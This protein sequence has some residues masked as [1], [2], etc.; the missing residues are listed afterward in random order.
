MIYI[1]FLHVLNSIS[2]PR[3]SPA[4]DWVIE[5]NTRKKTT[6]IYVCA[7]MYFLLT[8]NEN[9]LITKLL[10]FSRNFPPLSLDFRR[11][12]DG[13]TNLWRLAR[14]LQKIF[15]SN[16]QPQFYDKTSQNENRS[17]LLDYVCTSCKQV[18]KLYTNRTHPVYSFIYLF[19][20]S[21]QIYGEILGRWS[22]DELDNDILTES[23][24]QNASSTFLLAREG[25]THTRLGVLSVEDVNHLS[26]A[27]PNGD[28]LVDS[29]KCGEAF[30]LSFWM[31]FKGWI[32]FFCS[33]YYNLL[34]YTSYSHHL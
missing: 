1:F 15:R 9:I 34:C 22:L 17:F 18:F 21:V 13:H 27:V 31:R 10:T 2:I 11:F 28:C 24:S 20:F 25:A 29:T 14:K 5:L 12:S 23:L 33:S 4:N 7:T 8:Y 19:F 6:H 30:G 16:Q 26:V 3:V 32:S